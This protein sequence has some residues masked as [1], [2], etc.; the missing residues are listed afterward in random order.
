MPPSNPTNPSSHDSNLVD[1]L[2]SSALDGEYVRDQIS[3]T[4][5]GY[6]Q[7]Q[8]DEG[9]ANTPSDRNS[10]TFAKIS[11]SQL[12]KLQELERH[13]IIAAER[14]GNIKEAISQLTQIINDYPSYASAYNNRAQALRLNGADSAT[15]LADLDSAI[16]YAQDDRTRGQ[17][18]T[19]RG[20]VLK[21]ME[22]DQDE[23]FN[24][25]AQGAKCG[26]EVARLAMAKENPYAK[27]CG[28][29]VS[30]AM[31]QLRTTGSPK[32]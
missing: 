30:E 15:V 12:A 2:L 22:G 11:E 9:H 6:A 26:N 5:S 16:R 29:I 1:I 24:C 10:D 17:A 25:F 13:A 32:S 31:R 28:K 14:D 3:G 20:I 8:Q 19:Q 21:A 4:F 27:M 18:Y 23:V 7:Q